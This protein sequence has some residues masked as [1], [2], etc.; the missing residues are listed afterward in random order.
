MTKNKGKRY[1]GRKKNDEVINDSFFPYLREP[2]TLCHCNLLFS[3]MNNNRIYYF[4]FSYSNI[5][6]SSHPIHSK[7][8]ITL[9]L[10]P[11]RFFFSSFTMNYVHTSRPFHLHWMVDFEKEE[12][13]KK[14]HPFQRFEQQLLIQLQLFQCMS[15]RI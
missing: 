6:F 8:W 15:F 9:L 11:L 14:R 3:L 12:E 13:K 7:L 2:R 10:K 4:L 1:L 5:W